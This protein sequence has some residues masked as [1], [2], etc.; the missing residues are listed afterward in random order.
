MAQY[1]GTV[2][3]GG[4]YHNGTVLKRPTKPW[5]VDM[6][7]ISGYGGGV[8]DIPKMSDSSMA[9]YTFGNTPSIEANRLQWHKIKDGDKT[10]LICDRAILVYVSWNDLNAQGYVTGKTITIDGEKYKCRLITGG[11]SK[12]ED[13][14]LNALGT[15][16]NNEWDRFIYCEAAI[17]GLPVPLSSDLDGRIDATDKRSEHNQ[18]WNW[19]GIYCLCQEIPT[20]KEELRVLRGYG[21]PG[22]WY[23][24][25]SGSARY[26]HIGFRPVLEVLN[27]AP[28]M[29]PT[30]T[31]PAQVN[32]GSTVTISWGTSTD[33]ESNLEGYKAERSLDGGT[34][35][36]QIYQGSA[37]SAA[38]TVP[39]GSESVMYRVKAYDAEGL[40]SGWKT[41]GQVTVINNTAPTVPGPL[42]VPEQVQGGGP[43][44]I[45][46]GSSS[47]GENNLAG[48]SLERQV[49]GGDWAVVYTGDQLSFTDQITKG[50][51]TVAYR[52]R[53]YDSHSAYSGFASSETRQVN[54]NTPPAITCELPANTSLG[55]KSEGFEVPYSVD[56]EEGDGVTVTE[57]V[58]G[59]AWRTFTAELGAE[60][61]FVLGGAD[62][63]KLLNGRHTL[64]ITADDGASSAVHSLSFTKSVTAASVTLAQPMAA[65]GPIGVCV[66]AVSG[67][68]PLDAD[69][70]VEVAN[71]ALDE[72]PAWEDCTAEVRGGVNYVFENKAAA[73]GFAF[74][75]RLNASRGKSGIGGY[76]TSVQGGFQ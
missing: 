71:N 34:T 30:I 2:Q 24:M 35:W 12:R 42:T 62:F 57:A 39:F 9:N 52:V 64:S 76:I 29:P 1:L 43:L 33:A 69:F 26:E 41:S 32:G 20:T 74:N 45:S 46:W 13:S 31:V 66:L 50:W 7:P 56:D 18:F 58:D 3:L 55:A 15:P 6:E 19:L 51:Q 10:L 61:R 23:D 70:R 4:F 68:I 60:N 59:G 25:Y 37:Q 47:D 72:A 14:N 67:F 49:D 75:F 40:E 27:T 5:R 38:G 44:V 48:Y 28:T 8:G 16:T 73:N 11:S 22:Q 65:D 21:S 63:M 53:A 36:V 17:T 54:N